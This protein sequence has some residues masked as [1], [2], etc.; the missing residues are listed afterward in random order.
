M[1]FMLT[2]LM[3]DTSDSDDPR[4]IEALLQQL[5]SADA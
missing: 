1:S 3:G 5:D 2:D 4:D